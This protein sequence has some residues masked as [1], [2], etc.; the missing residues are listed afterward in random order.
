MPEEPQ[1]EPPKKRDFIR[2]IIAND[3]ARG[4]NR[5]RVVTRF[6][7]EPNG[8]LHIGHA[9]AICLNFSI[10]QELGDGTCHLRFDDTNPTKEETEYVESI[11][12]DVRW[13]GFDWGENLFYA[14]D[15]FD[16]LYG[17][18]VQL[19]EDRKAYVD[20]QTAEQI[21][22]ARGSLTEPGT[23]SPFRDRPVEENLDLFARMKAGEFQDGQHVLRGKIDMASANLNLRDPVLY[24][25]LHAT[26]HRTGDTWCIYPM[27]DFAHPLSDAIEGITHSLCTLEF[28]NHRPLYEWCVENV[29]GL[30]SEPMQREFA[31]LNL[32]YTVMSKRKLL[33]L[34]Q[35]GLVNGWDDPRMPTLSGLRRRGFPAAAIRNLC[36]EIGITKYKSLTD[37]ALLENAVREEL[38]RTAQRRMA[39]LDPLKVTLTN[40]P[41]DETTELQLAN[42]PEDESAGT[43]TVT[44]GSEIYIERNDFMEEAPKKFFRLKPGGEVRLRGSYIIRCDEVLKDDDG[45]ITG[46]LGTA[47]LDTLGKNPA[48]GRKVKGVIHWVNVTCAVPAEV[49]IYD[50]LITVE[51][52]EKEEG[53]FLDYINPDS[54][55]TLTGCQMEPSLATF[56]AGQPVQF[57]RLGYFTPDSKDSSPDTPVFNRT[58]PLRDTWAK[59][60]KKK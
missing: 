17:F 6:P 42:N 50:R 38:N 18:A 12:E 24:R 16:R 29:R 46:L 41:E 45:N 32:T 30:E 19:I 52:P 36:D 44:F 58:V 56:D 34:V 43:R 14:S 26:H 22:E 11:M 48:D 4:G 25:I 10:A 3:L 1:T 51:N 47:D 31:R 15:Y 49:R 33:Q 7:P 20:S 39:V 23:A 9:K 54:L 5:R 55:K 40:I 35:D 27:Y 2:E 37:V 59:I 53:S 57:E 28:E 8:Y 13:L 21:R 60:A